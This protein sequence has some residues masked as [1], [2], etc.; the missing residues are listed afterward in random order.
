MIEE[1]PIKPVTREVYSILMDQEYAPAISK[2]VEE[3]AYWDFV[4]YHVPNGLK[5]Y[6]FWNA[7]K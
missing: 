3:Y 7:I 4:K 5:P 6:D 1:A 2:M